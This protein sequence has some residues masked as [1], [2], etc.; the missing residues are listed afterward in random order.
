MQKVRGQQTRVFIC[1]IDSCPISRLWENTGSC[2]L[3]C[4]LLTAGF[5]RG[6]AKQR[7]QKQPE[8][9]YSEEFELEERAFEP[10]LL[11]QAALGF[12]MDFAITEN[13]YGLQAYKTWI[14]PQKLLSAKSWILSEMVSGWDYG[15]TKEFRT[16]EFN[17]DEQQRSCPNK[18]KILKSTRLSLPKN[19][20]CTT[21][22]LKKLNRGRVAATPRDTRLRQHMALPI[23]T[24]GFAGIQA[25]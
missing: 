25:P 10:C 8:K 22:L 11:L 6:Q 16:K 15:V 18:L 3:K 13:V 12:D 5:L 2:Q 21:C 24:H 23:S 1:H 19:I 9:R 20:H 4:R 14:A 7:R 17:K